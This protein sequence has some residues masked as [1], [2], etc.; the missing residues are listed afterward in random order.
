MQANGKPKPDP[1]EKSHKRRDCGVA[2]AQSRRAITHLP[3]QSV[4]CHS[5]CPARTVKGYPSSEQ[6]RGTGGGSTLELGPTRAGHRL[7]SRA[8]R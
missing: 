8:G 7:S 6:P 4:V 3:C 5:D 2:S 1:N